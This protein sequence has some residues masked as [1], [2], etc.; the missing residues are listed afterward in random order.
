MKILFI[1]H[2]DNN[3]G[4]NR[5]WIDNYSLF[6]KKY[7]DIETEV[8][9]DFQPGFNIYIVSK[10]CKSNILTEIKEKTNSKIGIIQPSD[11][12]KDSLEKILLC[13]FFICGSILEK[14]YYLKYKKP[15]FIF[16]LVEII[17]DK[18]IKN[19]STSIKLGYHGNLEH[20][21]AF[22][23][24]LSNALENLSKEINL[25]LI[26]VYNKKLGSWKKPKIKILEHDWTFDTMQ[27][28]MGNVD[29]G[30]VPSLRKNNFLNKKSFF[31]NLFFKITNKSNANMINDYSIQFKNNTN[32]GRAFVFHQL[33]VPVVA[34]FSP[35]NFII[36]GDPKCGFLASSE[37]GWY[38]AIKELSEDKLLRK[39]ISENAFKKFIQ[40]YNPKDYLDF[41]LSEIKK[42]YNY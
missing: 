11:N 16:P 33:K 7:F 40:L 17:D 37:E 23:D 36:N 20:L 5:I 15:C 39:S 27:K 28:E 8:S 25:E 9:K 18:K 42:L 24:E 10:Y 35:E 6:L 29:I 30:L 41:F 21:K 31:R 34:D 13:D 32:A 38:N 19:N 12:N 2:G 4:S 22:P 26:V 14:D 1:K 3:I